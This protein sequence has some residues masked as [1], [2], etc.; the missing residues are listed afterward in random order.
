MSSRRSFIKKG[1]V[2]LGS[3]AILP[4][5]NSFSILNGAPNETVRIGVIGTGDRGQG[6]MKILNRIKNIDV[7]AI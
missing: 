7:V 3:T 6:L 5:F 2:A 4:Q 1:T